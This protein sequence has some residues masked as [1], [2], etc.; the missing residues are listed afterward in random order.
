LLAGPSANIA[1]PQAMLR[2]AGACLK[3][4]DQ[5]LKSS[6]TAAIAHLIRAQALARMARTEQAEAAFLLTQ[7]T[8]PYEGWLAARRLR[9]ALLNSGLDVPLS[10]GTARASEIDVALQ[11]DALTVLQTDDYLP[12]LVQIYQRQP[13]R[14]AWLLATVE[15]APLARKR[16]FLTVLRGSLRGAPIGGSG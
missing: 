7:E 10:G 11:A 12:V 3:R 8:A 6:P 15:Q 13:D 16:A 1:D 14:R 4:A 2:V 9:F 5:V